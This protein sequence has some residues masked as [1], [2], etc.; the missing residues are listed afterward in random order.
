MNQPLKDKVHFPNLDGLRFIGAF[1][2]IVIHIENLKVVA[3]KEPMAWVKDYLPIGG[4]DVSLFFVLSGF[5]ITFLL[6]KEKDKTST[7][8]LKKFYLR[9]MLKIW[10]LY[11]L[12]GFIG[13]IILPQLYIYSS[14]NYS[15][16]GNSWYSALLY[17]LFL[18]PLMKSMA[19]GAAWSVRVEELFYLLWAVILRSTKKY[20]NVLIA[21]VVLGF[22]L[23]NASA[24]LVH[25]KPILI[26]K[27]ANHLCT[28]YRFGCMAIGGIAAYLHITDR[29]KLLSFLYRKDLQYV[30]YI[31][32]LALFI[33]KVH[34]PGF[35]FEVYSIFFAFL[36]LNLA[37]NEQSILC[38]DY[39]LMNYLGKIS[40]GLYLYNPIMRIFCLAF[41][42]KIYNRPLAG[43]Q[44][45]SVLYFSAI[46]STIL[47]SI[48]SYE[49]FEKPFLRAKN[50]FAVIKTT[51]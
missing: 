36:V 34:L 42:E 20:F 37:T 48:L 29:K 44:M 12:I 51:S 9:R 50:R 32:L 23:R 1:L 28:D 40:Y 26:F 30:V 4:L 19:I 13:L 25:I 14:G 6:L 24:F 17:G 41:T 43:W 38:F 10:P 46:A 35:N 15:G 39:P 31:V 2:I 16:Y 3:G 18:P 45:N 21:I 5:L 7:I 22:F 33:F 49:F 8:N 47:I 11:Y 27:I